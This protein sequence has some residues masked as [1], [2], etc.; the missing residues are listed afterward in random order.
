M[1]KA[2]D[3]ALV[4]G[5]V[6]SGTATTLTHTGQTFQAHATASEIHVGDT[7]VNVTT[8]AVGTIVSIESD[9]GI[10]TSALTGGTGGNNLWNAGDV[11]RINAVKVST[12][13]G[14]LLFTR[15]GAT[16]PGAGDNFTIT[17]T[18]AGSAAELGITATLTSDEADLLIVESDGVTKHRIVLDLVNDINELISEISAQS[19]GRIVA[20]LTADNPN[21]EITPVNEAN[22]G[23]TIAEVNNPGVFSAAQ[24]G[25]S[26][27]LLVD[28]GKN[29]LT[30]GLA[31]VGDTIYNLTDGSKA[32]IEALHNGSLTTSPLTGGTDNT[33]GS[34]DAYSLGKFKVGTTNA[35]LAA[36]KLGLIG[37]DTNPQDDTDVPDGKVI[38]ATI[39]GATLLDR[40]FISVPGADTNAD[41]GNDPTLLNDV[42]SARLEVKAGALLSDIEITAVGGGATTVKANGFDFTKLDANHDNNPDSP[43][44]IEIKNVA[45]FA[46][47]IYSVTEV[48]NAT[49]I[50]LA[51]TAIG[52]VGQK[53]GAGVL[54]TGLDASATFGFIEIGLDGTLDLGAELSWGFNTATG[55]A[56]AD[57]RLTAQEVIDGLDEPLSLM[58]LPDL[59]PIPVSGMTTAVG[60]TTTLTDTNAHF[61]TGKR[62][63]VGDV[64]RNV[65]QGKTATIQSIDSDTALTMSALT[66]GGTWGNGD[67]YEI[68]V[69]NFGLADASVSLD[70]AGDLAG[71]AAAVGVEDP[72]LTL[73]VL[74]FGDP[75][76]G[77]R[78]EHASYAGT[79]DTHFTLSGNFTAKLPAGATLKFGDDQAQIVSASFASGVTTVEISPITDGF[80]VPGTLTGVDV[81]LLPK[82]DVDMSD[83]GDILPDFQ[84]FGLADIIALLQALADYLG[85]FESFGFLNEPIPLIDTSVNDLLGFAD[86]FATALQEFQANPA[87]SLQ[88]LEDKLLEAL[89]INN[90]T[91]TGIVGFI[92]DGPDSP[93][94]SLPSKVVNLDFDVPSGM[95]I[96]DIA[97]GTSFSEGL[98]VA[99]PGL[100]FG[101]ALSSLGLGSLL[102]LAGSANLQAEGS[103]LARLKLGVDIANFDVDSLTDGFSIDDLITEIGDHLFLFDD[104]GFD[105]RLRVAGEDI[106]F[107]VGVGPFSLTIGSTDPDGPNPQTAEIELDGSIDLA[108]E[109]T[110]FTDHKVSFT[111]F[112][113]DLSFDNV[114]TSVE[115]SISGYLPVFFPNDSR[116][117]G[118]IRIGGTDSNNT[119]TPTGDLVNLI[120]TLVDTGDL[121]FE[122]I[123]EDQN[124]GLAGVQGTQ[125]N[126]VAI[127]VSD[128]IKGITSFDLSK[129]SI[130]DNV[131]LAVDGLDQVLELLQDTFDDTN[132]TL[133]L[134]GNELSKATGFIG[135]M[136]EDFI[137]PL[138]NLVETAKDTAADFADANKNV[139]SKAIFDVLGPSGA[140]ILLARDGFVGTPSAVGD[141]VGLSTNLD[142]FLFPEEGETP[143]DRSQVFMEWDLNLGSTLVNAPLDIGFDLGIP[144]LGLRTEGDLNINIDWALD[145]GFGLDFMDGFYLKTDDP[146]E[147]LFNAQVTLPGAGIT[148]TL[149]F[150]GLEGHDATLDFGPYGEKNTALGAT[151]K[152]DIS[153]VIANGDV[154][155]ATANSITFTSTS[156]GVNALAGKLVKIVGGNGD[157]QTRKI[158]SNTGTS[159]TIEGTWNADADGTYQILDP[160]MGFTEFGNID[161]DPRIAA[162]ASAALEMTL[163]LSEDLV[164]SD[165]ASGFPSIDAEFRFLW[166]LGN[167]GA[168]ATAQDIA[169]NPLTHFRSFESLG[170][171]GFG[172]ISNGLKLVSFEHIEL[173]LGS[174][175]GD[176]LGPIV[177][178]VSQFTEP[179]QPIIDF[180]TSPVPIIGQLGLDITWLD[181]AQMVAGDSVNI[182]LIQSIAEIISLVNQIAALSDGDNVKLPIGN[183]VIYDATDGGTGFTPALWDGGMNRDSTLTSALSAPGVIG[184]I[185]GTGS[186]L[187]SLAE[188]IIS[189]VLGGLSGGSGDSADVLQGLTS[190]QAAGGFSFPFLEHPDQIFGLLMGK[191]VDLVAYDL[192]ELDFGFEFHQFFSIFGPLGV[193]IGLIVE[194]MIDSA[195]IYDTQGIREFVDSGFKNPALLLDGFAIAADPKLDGVDDP[196]LRFFAELQ[197]AAELNLGIARAGVAAAFGFQILFNLFDP[198]G[199]GRIRLKELIGNIENQLRAPN[200]A[201]KLLAPLAIFDVSGE[202]FA[203]LFAFLEIDFGF[204]T[205]EKEFPIFGPETLLSFQIDFFRPPVLATELDNGDLLIHTGK[206]ADQRLL[207]NATDLSEHILISRA[208]ASGDTLTVNISSTGT[209][210]GGD[211]L[212]DDSE[213]PLAYKMKKGGKI[214]FD[215]GK[216]DDRL[217]VSGF[218]KGEVVFDIDMGVGNDEVLLSGGKDDEFSTIVGGKGVDHITGSDGADLIYGGSGDDTIDAGDGTDIVFGDEGEIGTDTATGKTSATDGVDTI[219]GQGGSDI[220]FGGGGR[221][222]LDGGTSGDSDLLIG[223]GGVVQ[224]QAGAFKTFAN[225]VDLLERGIGDVENLVLD[226]SAG[227]VLVGDE[228]DIIFG[229]AGPDVITGTSGNDIIFGLGGAD[230]IDGLGGNDIIFGDGGKLDLGAG[231]AGTAT[232]GDANTLTD[233]GANFASVKVGDY[234]WNLS[235]DKFVRVTAVNTVTSF[236]TE[237]VTSW[238]GDAYKFFVPVAVAGSNDGADVIQGGEG[239]DL[240]FGGGGGDFLA[241]DLIVTAPDPLPASGGD[242]RIYG[243]SGADKMFG[244]NVQVDSNGKTATVPAVSGDGDDRLFGEGEA[245]AMYGGGGR[246][247]M[248]GGA[249]SDRL[250]GGDDSDTLIFNKGSDRLDGEDGGDGYFAIMQGGN[251]E[252]L[253]IAQDT[254]TTGAD[255][256][257]VNGTIFDDQFLLR[258]NTAGSDAFI[259]MIK[260]DFYVE[261]INYGGSLERIVVNGGFGNDHFAIDDTA[262]EITVN[263]EFGDDTFQVGQIFRSQRIAAEANISVNPFDDTFATIETT[264]GFLS[265]GISEPMTINGGLGNDRFVVYHNKAVLQL[266]GEGGDDVFEIRAFALVGSQEPQRE[267]TDLSGGEGADLVMYAVN[268]PVNIDGGDGFDT[269]VVIGTEFGDDFV[270]TEDGVFGAGLTVSFVNIESLRLDAAEGSDR[271]FV[272]STSEKFITEIFGGL[273]E[274]TVFMSGATPP[275]V[276]NDLRGHSGVVLHDVESDDLRYDGQNIF[277]IS[278]N[279]ADNDEP[280]I[281]VRPTDGSTIIGEGGMTDEFSVMLTRAPTR[282]IDVFILAPLPTPSARERGQQMFRVTSAT[283]LATGEPTVGGSSITLRF[284]ETNW[285]VPQ[286]VEVLA[287]STSFDDLSPAFQPI[288]TRPEVVELGET[289]EPPRDF[290]YDDAAYEGVRFGVVNIS[291]KAS[292]VQDD[293]DVVG[294]NTARTV[295]TVN[296]AD[297]V[298]FNGTTIIGQNLQIKAGPGMGQNRFVTGYELDGTHVHLTLDREY[299][300]T[301]FPTTASAWLIQ[302]DDS[303]VGVMDSFREDTAQLIED[304]IIPETTNPNDQRSIFVDAD[305]SVLTDAQ[306]E[307]LVGATIE[308]VA[309]TGR[310]QQR[311]ILGHG[312]LSPETTLILNGGW[313]TNPDS[314]SVYRIE[315]YDGLALPSVSVQVNDNDL[316]GINLDETRGFKDDGD[317]TDDAADVVDDYDT[318]TAVIEGGDGDQLG[319][320]DVIRVQLSKDPLGVNVEVGLIYDSTQLELRTLDGTLITNAPGQ[321]LVFSDLTPQDLV[322]TALVDGMREGF[323]TSLIGFELHSSL[324]DADEV[325]TEKLQTFPDFPVFYVGLENAPDASQTITVKA[326]GV[327]LTRVMAPDSNGIFVGGDYFVADNKI[328]FVDVTGDPLAREGLI[329]VTYT[330]NRRNFDGAFTAPILARINDADAPT[331]IVRETGGSTDVIEVNQTDNTNP[332]FISGA[333]DTSGSPWQDSY[334]LVLSAA[335]TDDVTV[336]VTPDITKTTRTG[337]IR[338]D[339]VQVEVFSSDSRAVRQDF[340]ADNS[341]GSATKL[342]DS[343][344]AFIG[345]GVKIGTLVRTLSGKW[346]HVTDVMDEH[347]LTTETVAGGWN[348][349]GYTF[350]NWKVTFTD[351]D[352]DKPVEIQVR[353][354]DD[355]QV[356]GGDTQVFAPG[357]ATL[358]GILGPVRVEGAGGAGSLSLGVPV[359]LP[360]ETNLRA[361]DG[362]VLGFQAG[363]GFGATEYMTVHIDDLWHRIDADNAEGDALKTIDDLIGLTVEMARGEGVGVVLNPERPFEAFD[364]FWLIE[365]ITVDPNDSDLRILELKNPSQI[366]PSTLAASAVPVADPSGGPLTDLSGD[367][368]QAYAITALSA[369]FFVEETVQVDVM[370]VNDQDSLADSSG[371]LTST[372]LY[373]LNM[374]PDIAIGGQQRSGGI[375]YEDL[376]VIEIN[377]GKGNNNLEVFGTQTREDGYQSWT[378][379][380]T[381]D[382]TVAF[383]DKKGDDVV[384]HLN[385]ADEQFTG[386]AASAQNADLGSGI[387]HT[388]ITVDQSFAKDSLQGALIAIGQQGGVDNAATGQVRRI[389]YND[390]NV[391]TVEGRWDALP[392]GEDYTI[393]N[394]ADGPIAVNLQAG[395]DSL[396]ASDS[397]L[398]VVAFGG[399]GQD[400]LIGGAGDDILFGDRGRV[401]YFNEVG[402]IVTRLGYAPEPIT[403]FVTAQVEET[404]LFTLEDTGTKLS[405]GVPIG[406]SFP[407]PDTDGDEESGNEDI[408]LRGLYVDINN[409]FGFLQPVKL[410]GG[411]DATHLFLSTLGEDAGFDPELDLPGPVS[412]NPSEYRISTIPEDQTDG[413]VR[414]PTLLITVDND[415]GDDDII[416]GG[417]GKDTVFGGAGGDTIDAGGDDDIVIG[418][419][420]RIDRERDPGASDEL[421]VFA[422]RSPEAPVVRTYLQ[423]VRTIAF[424]EGGMDDISGGAGADLIFGGRDEDTIYGDDSTAS[425]GTA[426]LGDAVVGDNGEIDFVVGAFTDL[427]SAITDIFTTDTSAST[428]GDDT[429]HGDGGRDILIGGVEDDTIDGGDDVDI[430][431]GDDGVVVLDN[432]KLVSVTDPGTDGDD[433][434]SGGDDD[435][436]IIGGFGNDTI[437]GDAAVDILVGDAAE[438]LYGDDGVTIV[439][440]ETVSR[441]DT[442][443]G[444]DTVFGGADDDIVIGGTGS[445]KLD[446]GS[447]DDLIFGDNV[448]LVLNQGSGDAIQPRFRTLSGATL[449]DAN[450]NPLVGGRAPTPYQAPAWADWS[451]TLD[452]TREA[453]HFGDDYIAGGADDDEIFGQLG[454]DTIQG[455]GSIDLAIDAGAYRDQS[456]QLV[457]HASVE[458]SSDGDD[459]I[460]GSEGSDVIFGNLGQDDLTGGSSELFSLNSAGLRQDGADLIFGGAGTEILR[461]EQGNV[462]DEGDASHG[463]DADMIL[464]DNGNIFRIV[465]VSGG[466]SAYRSFEYDN[467]YG[468]QLVVRAAQLL[469][470][471]PGGVLGVAPAS[472]I[473]DADEI[474]GESGDDFIYGQKGGDVLFGEGQD[475]DLIGGTGND[476]ISGGTGDDGVIGDD[477]RIITSRNNATVGEPLNGVAPLLAS[478]PSTKDSNGNVLNE[479]ISTPGG[480]QQ[481]TIN[482]AGAL[483]KAVN[484]APFSIDT[485]WDGSA[486]EFGGLSNHSSDDVIYGGLGNDWLHGG[487]GDDA[488]SGAEALPAFYAAPINAGN[489]LG[490]NPAT[491]EFAQYDEYHPL[492]KIEGF[493]L[494]FDESEGPQVTD[495][496]YGTVNTDGEDKIFGDLGND[497]LV[498]GTGRDDLYG[499]WGDDLM[500]ADDNQNT[501]GDV[502]NDTPDTHPSYED[503]AYGGAG[504]DVLIANTGGDRLI[505]WVGEFNSYIVP[506]APFGLGTVS[507]TLQPQLQEF[508][509]ALSAS[510]GAD[511][512][513]T[514]DVGASANTAR[515]GEPQGELGVVIQKDFAWQ[516]QTGGPRDPQAGNIPGGKRDVLRSATFDNASATGFFADSGKWSVQNG[517]LQVSASSLHADAVSVF[518]VGDAL[519]GYFE[520]QASIMAIKP[521]AGWKA[522]SYI[523]F[524]YQAK[525][526]FRFAGLDVALNK[527]VMGHRDASGWHVDEQAPVPGGVKA[528]QYYNLLLSVNG[529][530]ATLV[531]DN[532]NVFS[533]TYAPRVVDGYSYGLNWGM[534]G[535]GSDNSRGA[536]D[537][538]RVQVLPPQITFDQTEDFSDGVANLFT[539][540]QSGAWSVGNGVY[541]ATPSSATS[542]SIL[543]LGP[544]NL[545]VSSYLE[546]SARVNAN[547]RAG[548]VFDRYADG[549]FKFVAL[550]APADQ[551]IIGHYTPKG[552]WVSDTAVAKTIDAGTAYTLGVALKGSTVS[553]TLNG[554]VVLGFAFN[555][556]TVDGRFGL[557]ATGGSASFDDVRVKTNDPAFA[558]DGGGSLVAG[559][560]GTT[561]S[562]TLTQDEL[563]GIATVA[564]SQWTEALGAGDARLAALADVRIVI[565]DLAGA[566]LGDTAGNTV[567][568]DAD[569]AGF[570]W[571]VDVSPASSSEFRVR[572]DR[573]IF[574]A[575]PGSEAYGKMDLLTAVEHELGHLLGFDHT[576]PLAVMRESLDPS[577]RYTLDTAPLQEEN[578]EPAATRPAFDT[579][580][581]YGNMGVDAPIDW[582]ASTSGGWEVKLSPY[583]TGRPAKNGSPNLTGFDVKLL[584]KEQGRTQPADFDGMGKTLLGKDKNPQA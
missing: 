463:R 260:Q 283:A 25:G 259:A 499:G 254:G 345:D 322:V 517:V 116:F 178:Q 113:G 273:G 576:S 355:A 329:D 356:D 251:A 287:D 327:T 435:D 574:A 187:G 314:T 453:G 410:I 239:D 139:I 189:G 390:G 340:T 581:G 519:P 256:L 34:G 336:T 478:D 469:D 99:L 383:N 300:A 146:D 36:I 168:G 46:P 227:D 558:A 407:V 524:D 316:P 342:V 282:P 520:V 278:A 443:N 395:N 206:F 10:T 464:G 121:N 577:V 97:W 311:L 3:Q 508:L 48:V 77:T 43:I 536:F 252:S 241:G 523:V 22:T 285:Y 235:E 479:A 307:G 74:T 380:N 277:G 75:F 350:G 437:R 92:N 82:V 413:V 417:G 338:H 331:V 244:D 176:V 290:V 301:E 384:L 27:I 465:S 188:G 473:G 458:A 539:G 124:T 182:A 105:A 80:T 324:V 487:S 286:I 98:D 41:A 468:E 134:I 32:T 426:D 179:M 293:G 328:V 289:G 39:A 486:D 125:A 357:P 418:D 579:Y 236:E 408:G 7:I 428:G 243:G 504:R 166:Q 16:S 379:I 376:E 194:I 148:G 389:L 137:A 35:S 115:G 69:R 136:R 199:D 281:V 250:F 242:D 415:L 106:G 521:T 315:R 493:L 352:W 205:F 397:D 427:F 9:T 195:F 209:Q 347:T 129:L 436:L 396:D 20:T 540:P 454:D 202:I 319:E 490:Y 320:R 425:S 312:L 292:I 204:F 441:S 446:G 568:V 531:L 471:T 375:T 385:A 126:A 83:L 57:G 543:D 362:T 184:D 15:T 248:D 513:R 211:F 81:V 525:D 480:V 60:T 451:I 400:T 559:A 4:G 445:D 394:E 44:S 33:W 1:Q 404:N 152:V 271:V 353:A 422:P 162:E 535:V 61:E 341:G 403:G 197:A 198:D 23:L 231:G 572:L 361:P 313:R 56:G 89:G 133:P 466:A 548:F 411:N 31:K 266:N 296:A 557:L 398:G 24:A 193:S 128:V 527:L 498:G 545:N 2:I 555:A 140:N 158:L 51:S 280:F 484:L 419:A 253:V 261:R 310:G 267:R 258:A 309:G 476:W 276:S 76:I 127:D 161:I 583:D 541:S 37:T 370:F 265:N 181:L 279:V 175:I 191:N 207:G 93:A 488:I 489:V 582:Q 141:Y 26:G 154:Q 274:D 368:A 537:N 190:H 299:A 306:S 263:G 433:I 564:I 495:P 448:L 406:G 64:V 475:D 70:L 496:T 91:L 145:L 203:R 387:L 12:E 333:Q 170:E 474:H 143:P 196:E 364:R 528:D 544:D 123:S 264:R 371:V 501:N 100:D 65:T 358:S 200:D 575:A 566:E 249:G 11:Y 30:N 118:A 144:G 532:K 573:N 240:I 382:E 174:F 42:L 420:G 84:N 55:T 424:A 14:R 381:G 50:K 155:S 8:G 213:V 109:D 288:A 210:Y 565:G 177:D 335:P 580:A 147:L 268:A 117:I 460:E 186:D 442:R 88:T 272:K 246:D 131:L 455:D 229:T 66:G 334:Q 556:A 120:S 393:T 73:R 405:G 85:Q 304:G 372:R 52:I 467:A 19:G 284:D 491:G 294:L 343:D 160:H 549:S 132:I 225:V 21:G 323:H 222:S 374:G 360:G 550:D 110:L 164:G 367:P 500:N 172:A 551:V 101:D 514:A 515:N 392:A 122:L 482:G 94:L 348:G 423:R 388:T 208:G 326:N 349:Q 217:E 317:A 429:I 546:L 552:G 86:D 584:D 169:D 214:I 547:G 47:G 470:Y 399:L 156:F 452:Q 563:D 223:G 481:A 201:D 330:F 212:G 63:A 459:Y 95:L 570:G 257:V 238:A 434:L 346:V 79:D 233:S 49:T 303:L 526:D 366:D 391:L 386:T 512:T 485:G 104:T 578:A 373:G 68:L 185:F 430:V 569:A 53:G 414:D 215:G 219:N 59:T 421:V 502:L 431:L 216:G 325:V 5:T 402:A 510:D 108:L 167:R 509:Y 518:H 354:I 447:E 522:N 507:R 492:T 159:L 409:G 149:G 308:I 119:F 344:A 511:P 337:G 365:A 554:Q 477:G 438:V 180:I 560:S 332:N 40:F 153:N 232:G 494:N 506:F 142:D 228:G 516:D 553:V 247:Y 262:A 58:L 151:F 90:N 114:D 237:V 269:V 218:S 13:G 71:L 302:D 321:R 439:R 275:I 305:G 359:M 54:Q 450:G 220:I 363:S 412:A 351:A 461:N 67:D 245:D 432:G 444:I 561:S 567:V 401:D 440:V 456:G 135:D 571:F 497:W 291:V 298:H 339:D 533:H 78:F 45:G 377:L 62:V 171:E 130:F 87:G 173:D 6:T 96:F 226:T 538:I 17:E 562:A 192:G 234:V 150:L 369:N 72:Q 472:D 505:D 503:R 457:V 318:I 416:S 224:F 29:F 38:G 102:D 530:N 28:A 542:V 297:L 221:D 111:D 462:V 255:L 18:T 230:V 270:I 157:D 183:F 483:K 295:L 107:R 534:L 378:L 103:V 449:Y 163:G 112:F 165:V 138:R 529:L